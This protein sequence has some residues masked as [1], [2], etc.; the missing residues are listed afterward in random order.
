[1]AK[2]P[3]SR[4]D[5]ARLSSQAPQAPSDITDVSLPAYSGGTVWVSHPLRMAAGAASSGRAAS[6]TRPAEARW[7]A[8]QPEN[9][10]KTRVSCLRRAFL[11][12]I[13]RLCRADA[14]HQYYTDPT[15]EEGA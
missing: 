14:R 6:I 15:T 3:D 7:R 8:E 9:Q 12:N 2:F 10:W 5:A 13:Q 11:L 4:I 1:M